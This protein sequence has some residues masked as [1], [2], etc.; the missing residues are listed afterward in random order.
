[1]PDMI[2]DGVGWMTEQ[3][4]QSA[5][6]RTL[7]RRGTSVATVHFTRGR[8]EYTTADDEGNVVTRVT[9]ATFICPRASLVLNGTIIEP[10]SGD[11][12]ELKDGSRTLTYEVLPHGDKKCFGLDATQQKLSIHTKLIIKQ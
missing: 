2:G 9:D 8:T 3:L 1:M 5:S 11:R 10:V 6:V 7:Y 12:I 4:Q